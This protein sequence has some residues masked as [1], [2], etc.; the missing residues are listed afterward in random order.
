MRSTYAELLVHRLTVRRVHTEAGKKHSTGV[1]WSSTTGTR[2]HHYE[3][4]LELDRELLIVVGQRHRAVVGLDRLRCGRG[5]TV[6]GRS[7]AA[8][9]LGPVVR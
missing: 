2:H 3:S 7:S 6:T 5:F 9:C 1:F 8:W 4:S